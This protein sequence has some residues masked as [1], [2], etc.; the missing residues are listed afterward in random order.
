MQ[1][2][3]QTVELQENQTQT[4]NFNASDIEEITKQADDQ[5]LIRLS[6]G[7][8]VLITNIEQLSASALQFSNGQACDLSSMQELQAA[9]L[10]VKE[11]EEALAAEAQQVEEVTIEELAEQE[12]GEAP[13]ELVLEEVE[14]EEII[15][16][17]SE[18]GEGEGEVEE[19]A[20]KREI[21]EEE[22]AQ[23]EPAAGEELAAIEP[24]AGGVENTGFSFTTAES[25]SLRGVD[26]IGAINATALAYQAPAFQQQNV[27][28]GID[29]DTGEFI[30][31][32]PPEVSVN[33][34]FDYAQ[35]LEDGSV[36]IPVVAT[37]TTP[38]VNETLTLQLTGIPTGW[39]F[40]GA[41]WTQTAPGTY[42]INNL[43]VN[44]DYAGGFTLRPPANSDID[45]SQL[46]VTATS[47]LDS[48]LSAFDT[49]SAGVIVDAVAD[50]PTVS[51]QNTSGQ[52][53]A[54][55][56][57]N[58]AAAVTDLDGSESITSYTIGGVLPGFSL[59]AGT[60]NGNGTWTLTPAQIN[61]LKIT[62][63]A[64]FDGTLNLFVRATAT[65]SP[66]DLDFIT[67]NNTAT[68]TANFTATWTP[69]ADPPSITV[70]GGVD[71]AQVLEDGSV[72]IPVVAT[73]TGQNETLSL[74][75][76]GIP[77]G[78]T[79]NGTG[80]T[81]TAPGTYVINN[82]PANT[83]YDGG[84]TLSPPADSDIDL[85]QLTVTATATAS[86]GDTSSASDSA[87]VI[88]DA[89]ADTPT[90]DG[91]NA[92]GL[93]DTA[94]PVNVSA[95]V[96][97][98][99]GSESITS[100]TIGG[101]PA[102]FTLSAGTNN[103]NGTWTLTPAQING[104]TISS[105]A[106]FNGTI[107]L[108]VT[109][110]AS[111][112]PN[113]NEFNSANDTATATDTFNVTWTPDAGPP[114]LIVNIDGSDAQV[115]E[116]GTVT[117]PVTATL[118]D[119][120]ETLT[121]TVTGIPSSWGF[122]GAGWVQTSP[123][124]YTQTLPTGQNYNGSITLSP[125]ADSD[126]DLSNLRFTATSTASNG[127][128]ATDQ[129]AIDVIVD[130]VA[131]IPTVNAQNS[132]GQEDQVLNVNV[133][134]AVTDVDGSESITSFTISG[135]PAGFT[136]SAGTNNGN[137]TWTLT[138]AQINNLKITP[139]TGFNGTIPLT[140][141]ATATEDP[142]DREFNS[143]ND[144]AI[145]SANFNVTWT[146]DA[147]P[148][149]ITVNGGVDNAQVLEDGSV[150]VPVVATLSGSDETLSLR[151]T[152]LQAGWT[153][154]GAGWTQVSAGTYVLNNLPANTNY[155]GGF[156]LRPPADSDV[157]HPSFTVTA[158]ATLQNGDTASSSDAAGVIVDAVADIP[159]VD[160]N[161][162]S[163]EVGDV[164]PITIS[165]AV[166]DTD[167]S[168]SISSVVISGVPTGFSLSAGTNNGNGTWTLSTGQL[169]S[170]KITPPASFVGSVN[171]T[172]RSTATED[173]TDLEFRSD[174]DNATNSD[175]FTVSWTDTPVFIV[176]ENPPEDLPPG[177]QVNDIIIGDFGGIRNEQPT[178]DYNLNLI[179][180]VSG[181]MQLNFTLVQNAIVSFLNEIGDYNTGE[182]R[183]NIQPFVNVNQVQAPIFGPGGTVIQPGIYEN[184]DAISETSNATTTA[185]LNEL[186]SF[187]NSLNAFGQTN[188]EAVLVEANNWLANGNTIDDALT[189]S[190]FI[191]DGNG[192]A[193]NN[194]NGSVTPTPFPVDPTGFDAA[195]VLDQ[196]NGDADG[197][198]EISTLQSMSDEVFGIIV[199]GRDGTV[200]ELVN[201]VDSDGNSEVLG[202][203]NGLDHYAD[204]FQN[205]DQVQ[206]LLPIGGDTITANGGDDILY[207]D[208]LFTDALANARGLSTPDGAGFA[209]FEILEA[210]AGWDRQDT[211]DYIRNNAEALAQE[212]I[213]NGQGRAGGH[214]T[215][216][217]GAG[218][219]LIFGQE[220]NDTIYG[221]AG[222]D[223]ISGGSG[224]DTF[225]SDS[226][227]GQDTITDFSAAE[228]D[229]LDFSTLLTNYD[230][231][232]D[233]ITDFLRITNNGTDSVIAIDVAGNGSNWQNVV[234]L[235][236]VSGVNLQD[237]VNNGSIV[238]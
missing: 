186:I 20:L 155:T 128:T 221:G 73:L 91:Q 67:T 185:G 15:E 42:V 54:V 13:D 134:A 216:Y 21:S 56:S 137:G 66:T 108:T 25:V 203:S 34:G 69:D 209:V 106:N 182:I 172:V 148:P 170:L 184:A 61:N 88:V 101:V 195:D 136:L 193:F 218:N 158:T 205:L 11:A 138:P 142:N 152:G 139:P 33:N 83:N 45:L 64:G 224:A 120:K 133:G 110:T 81:Q 207:G 144:T 26:A 117:I 188:P 6:S 161:G 94:L 219:D 32:T 113:D 236:D 78:W 223:T 72:F 131:D 183:V 210:T 37:L 121:V 38:I 217:G 168:E 165:T 60:N 225:V 1:D 231:I 28:V 44:T 222:N 196:I 176:G 174:N 200:A 52:E 175:T 55:L 86:N 206:E 111:E 23:I 48:G 129:E 70:N 169:A 74:Q 124:T 166:T 87:G 19:V 119:A 187:V 36:F 96:T 154:Q 3:T 226:L 114:T 63:P 201:A 191:S 93:E 190:F 102:G 77:S 14:I 173:P 51:A 99:D 167:G 180:D 71:N 16:E 7:E 147:N 215:I 125:P 35:V 126:I 156:T 5:I 2:T 204:L 109:A 202:T 228:G 97:D 197:S 118:S 76:T 92:S 112:D 46:T 47:T 4:L 213:L 22:I 157:D 163:G 199:P 151:L 85:S 145:G 177:S 24:A 65:D 192:N 238:V 105:P 57:I 179:V 132:A 31:Q 135:V 235:Q 50:I 12:L 107:P 146:P 98:L 214:D 208:V 29:P 59:S 58:V 198:D 41:D 237:L 10:E 40:V 162:S 115:L 39:T 43:P 181:S 233:S 150:F 17:A 189:Y 159:T 104:L 234:T 53:D 153:L 75:L 164:L 122:S 229:M 211:I 27:V 220:G 171:L 18:D 178:Q 8:T 194:P 230:A 82:L 9:L 100:Y 130:A 160:G 95:A 79:F 62:P 212:S 49:D 149:E 103:G 116:D 30:F 123:G 140:V 80:W 227:V 89:V 141:R 90:V 68:A 143:A 232:Q 84:F 127:D